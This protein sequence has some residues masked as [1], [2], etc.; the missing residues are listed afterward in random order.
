MSNDESKGSQVCSLYMFRFRGEQSDANSNSI[1]VGPFSASDT[2]D[3]D[4]RIRR[5]SGEIR[6]M[7]SNS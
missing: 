7:T 1:P 3:E 2:D 5:L 6:E 4:K